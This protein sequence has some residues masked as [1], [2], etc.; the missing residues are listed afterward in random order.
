MNTFEIGVGDGIKLAGIIPSKKDSTA[1]KL[2]KGTA[3]L[4]GLA[5]AAYGSKKLIDMVPLSNTF[6]GGLKMK[7]MNTIRNADGELIDNV[8]HST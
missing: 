7:I 4:G 3:I 2:V 8:T 5:A 6:S 1:K